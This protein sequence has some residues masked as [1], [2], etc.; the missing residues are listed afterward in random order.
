MSRHFDN[1]P[2]RAMKHRQRGKELTEQKAYI[3][4]RVISV[5]TTAKKADLNKTRTSHQLPP[6]NHCVIKCIFKNRANL[7]PAHAL[8]EMAVMFQFSPSIDVRTRSKVERQSLGFVIS[9][10]PRPAL[11]A[12]SFSEKVDACDIELA[13]NTD[14]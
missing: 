4:K 12:S 1:F 9:L 10:S 13:E 5:H 3:V 7:S 8:A 11:P 2:Q 14:V 6:V